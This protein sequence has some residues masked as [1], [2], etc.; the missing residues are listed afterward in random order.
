MKLEENKVVIWQLKRTFQDVT[1]QWLWGSKESWK[2]FP[3]NAPVLGIIHRISQKW[4]K[5]DPRIPQLVWWMGIRLLTQNFLLFN[6]ANPIKNNI[7]SSAIT[8]KK[9]SKEHNF[10]NIVKKHFCFSKVIPVKDK[11]RILVNLYFSNQFQSE[12]K[13]FPFLIKAIS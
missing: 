11:E 6:K 4:A 8:V 3:K 10:N 2:H 12:R 9:L 13:N 5:F 1:V 7:F